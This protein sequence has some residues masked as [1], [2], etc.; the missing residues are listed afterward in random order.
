MVK[1]LPKHLP[2]H[3]V[4]MELSVNMLYKSHW[5]LFLKCKHYYKRTNKC[6]KA[7][8][9]KC[10]MALCE[11]I[12]DYL[13]DNPHANKKEVHNLFFESLPYWDIHI[14]YAKRIIIAFLCCLVLSILC[15]ALANKF[16]PRDTSYDSVPTYYEK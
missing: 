12:E 11:S 13:A 2:L 5:L 1:L 9:K 4:K 7:E 6:S 14:F 16:L 8:L 3:A 15:F 10:S